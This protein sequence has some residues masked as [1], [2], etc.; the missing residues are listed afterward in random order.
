MSDRD[1]LALLDLCAAVGAVLLVV[2]LLFAVDA[3]QHDVHRLQT[4]VDAYAHLL[5]TAEP[6]P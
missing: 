4:A 2:A 3:L 6:T 1:I 5:P